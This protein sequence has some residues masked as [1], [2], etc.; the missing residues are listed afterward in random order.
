[1]L[2]KVR[3]SLIHFS[4]SFVAPSNPV[5]YLM[6]KTTVVKSFGNEEHEI[7]IHVHLLVLL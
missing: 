5:Y 6:M 3:G 4:S 1:M 7:Y 2:L